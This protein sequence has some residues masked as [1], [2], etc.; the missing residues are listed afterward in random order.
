M[1]GNVTIHPAEAT[2]K[3]VSVMENINL[4]NLL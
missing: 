3:V 2:A 4:V 1:S